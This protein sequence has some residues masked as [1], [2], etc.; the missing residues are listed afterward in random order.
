M[1]DAGGDQRERAREK[2]QKKE[3]DKNK[4]T[5]TTQKER[6]EYTLCV[7]LLTGQDGGNHASEAEGSR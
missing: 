6:E 5:G 4:K 1:T 2:Q 7:I 3:A